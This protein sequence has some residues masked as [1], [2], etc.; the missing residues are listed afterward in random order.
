MDSILEGSQFDLSG[1]EK[2]LANGL[3]LQFTQ[4]IENTVHPDVHGHSILIQLVKETSVFTQLCLGQVHHAI[5][6]G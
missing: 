6:F 4:G 1:R 5:Q 2:V 3:S